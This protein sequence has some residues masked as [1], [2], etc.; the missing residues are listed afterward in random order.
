MSDSPLSVGE[1]E[2]LEAG[3]KYGYSKECQQACY[4]VA[5]EAIEVANRWVARGMPTIE[6]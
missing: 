1:E 3:S 6:A 5:R 2:F 4:Q